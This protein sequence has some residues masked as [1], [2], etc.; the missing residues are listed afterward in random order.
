MTFSR[1]GFDSIGAIVSL[2]I[3]LKMKSMKTKSEK[4][5]GC[6]CVPAIVSILLGVCIGCTDRRAPVTVERPSHAIELT[7]HS[8]S[9]FQYVYRLSSDTVA[10]SVARWYP[11]TPSA[12]VSLDTGTVNQFDTIAARIASCDFGGATSSRDSLWSLSLNIDSHAVFDHM[13]IEE[14]LAYNSVDSLAH[15]FFTNSPYIPILSERT[16][17]GKPL[18][19]TMP[20][21]YGSCN[22]NNVKYEEDCPW[23]GSFQIE[24]NCAEITFSRNDSSFSRTLK[25]YERLVIDRIIAGIEPRVAVEISEE[26][27]DGISETFYINGKEV[28][29]MMLG[30][31]ELLP[32]VNYT[33]VWRY[34]NAISPDETQI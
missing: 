34:F 32:N 5:M 31:H 24:T 22:R 14:A 21:K 12:K 16:D 1:K 28:F 27:E 4:S 17:R 30:T 29:R 26:I 20:V 18:P 9:G 23:T 19:L 8:V 33:A 7:F 25:R 3:Y 15:L 13:P 10:F 6:R 2:P 11:V